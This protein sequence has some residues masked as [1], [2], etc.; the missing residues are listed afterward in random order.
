MAVHGFMALAL[1]LVLV[2]AVGGVLEEPLPNPPRLLEYYDDP[3]KVG[4][5]LAMVQ[6]L[7]LST[8]VTP[9]RSLQCM[10]QVNSVAPRARAV[11]KT[12]ASAVASLWARQASAAAR[13][14]SVSI[15]TT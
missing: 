6:T 10:S 11:A 12:I 3:I 4:I 14:I 13:A 5:V 15:G 7:I 1:G 9:G 2:F 8:S